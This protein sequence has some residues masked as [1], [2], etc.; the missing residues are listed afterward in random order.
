MMA[1]RLTSTPQ[2]EPEAVA[3]VLEGWL[4]VRFSLGLCWP[5]RSL[6]RKPLC[7]RSHGDN[8]TEGGSRQTSQREMEGPLSILMIQSGKWAVSAKCQAFVDPT[9]SGG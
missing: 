2:N 1:V 8:S 9:T 7:T 4:Q 6:A 5:N 3:T